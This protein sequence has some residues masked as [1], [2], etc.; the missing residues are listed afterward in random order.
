MLGVR[1]P[2]EP[3]GQHE[4]RRRCADVGDALHGEGE[5]AGQRGVRREVEG[6]RHVLRDERLGRIPHHQRLV[7][8]RGVGRAAGERGHDVP[9][10]L[11]RHPLQ[12]ARQLQ[13]HQRRR[14]V[15]REPGKTP[16]HGIGRLARLHQERDRPA[17][18]VF[19]GV[20][21]ERDQIRLREP[22][23]DVERPHGAEPSRVVGLPA[24]QPLQTRVHGRVR[25]T[26]LEQPARMLDVPVVAVELHRD[27]L[28]RGQPGK[29][30]PHGPIARVADLEDPAQGLLVQLR[31]GAVAL[32]LVV[33]VDHVHRAVGAVLEVQHL[34]PGIV[35]EQEVRAVRRRVTRSRSLQAIHVRPEAVDVV[36]EDRAAILRR[37]AVA[38]EIDH[39]AGVGV[40]A[41]GRARAAV[42]G[43]RP[44]LAHPVAVIG[45]GLDV[46]VGVRIEV[47]VRLPLVPSALDDVVQVL[48]D[49]GGR[50][51]VAVVV[52]V[53]PPRIARALG[54]SFEDVP[55]RVIAPDPAV[56]RRAVGVRRAG[57]ADLRVRE[58]AVGAVQPAVRSPSKR[59]QRL[60]RVLVAPSVE[61]HLRRPGR[62]IGARLHRDEQQVRSGADPDPAEPDL[63]AADEI[64]LVDEH[65]APVEPAVA[66][67]VL[68]D[69]DAIA[70]FALGRP[71]R[72]AV[73]L[74]HPQAAAIVDRERDR[75][76]DVGLGGGQRH[77]EPFGHG[78]RARRL[79]ARQARMGR[80]LERRERA[81]VGRRDLVGEERPLGVKAEPVERDVRPGAL[82]QVRRGRRACLFVH[83]ADHDE[84]ARLRPEIHDHGT[85]AGGV[86]T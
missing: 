25:T 53:E 86:G 46:V 20:V 34:A 69:Q 17:T 26:L 58:H 80:G 82:L 16:E 33:P 8:I 66:I 73:R 84:L 55:G 85:Q 6:A 59:V 61:Q 47:L 83:E 40:A 24:Q 48:D 43:M 31:V 27:Q 44:L 12:G 1:G 30:D 29:I 35:G 5:Q 65:L 51:G 11:D 32:V 72:V 36:H 70:A 41:S 3:I 75:T 71:Q 79:D 54:E 39:R 38:P 22:A 9:P 62:P 4:E 68:E 67:R 37:P 60:V 23:G 14:I 13:P 64:E 50:E 19:A 18:H 52:E 45:D 57:L 76:D 42:G 63:E 28:G 7:A 78:H 81:A 21:E 77:R 49:A 10:L 15:A 74:R 2:A 56:E